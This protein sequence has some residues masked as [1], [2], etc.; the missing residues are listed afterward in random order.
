MVPSTLIGLLLFVLLMLPGL[1]YVLRYERVY[2]A[3][4][5]SQL[6]EA[7]RIIVV[8]VASLTITGLLLAIVRWFFP[9]RT[10][11]FRGLVR[12]PLVF[13]REHHVHSI[14]WALGSI[15]VA[16]LAACAL[17]EI[18]IWLMRRALQS[19]KSFGG[20]FGRAAISDTSAW[21]RTF[22]ERR[23][24]NTE[25]IFVGLQMVD[26][27]YISGFLD[28]FNPQAMENEQR[29]LTLRNSEVLTSS[30]E[31][32]PLNHMTVVSAK[33]MVRMDVTYL[34]KDGVAAELADRASRNQQP[35]PS[36]PSVD[37]HTP[38]LMK[39]TLSAWVYRNRP[40]TSR[41]E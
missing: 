13:F 17:A 28:S 27:S 15:V 8:S 6:R 2:P 23:P 24:D 21:R 29:E 3:P 20:L 11:N 1:A 25:E 18:Q 10:L 41:P 34:S 14:W 19:K 30:G 26:K 33:A 40:P 36:T 22:V 37:A 35:V 7:L 4:A 16:T 9:E 39:R 38:G 31:R 12:E 5:H 32:Q